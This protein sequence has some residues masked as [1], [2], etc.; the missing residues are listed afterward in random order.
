MSISRGRNF[1][2]YSGMRSMKSPNA[3][4]PAESHI[5]LHRKA[6]RKATENFIKLAQWGWTPAKGGGGY[7]VI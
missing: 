6:S 3:V 1:P 2:T 4:S 5:S 7:S